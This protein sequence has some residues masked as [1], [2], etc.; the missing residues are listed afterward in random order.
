[1]ASSRGGI[2]GALVTR[3]SS[4]RMGRRLGGAPGSAVRAQRR[5]APRYGDDPNAAAGG[6]RGVSSLAGAS[7]LPCRPV[8]ADIAKLLRGSEWTYLSIPPGKNPTTA[9][10]IRGGSM[11][12]VTRRHS[13]NIES[14]RFSTDCTRDVRRYRKARIWGIPTSACTIGFLRRFIRIPTVA[15]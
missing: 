7:G 8:S 5:A 1:M 4:T 15:W 2:S 6:S 10:G 3:S 9:T 12:P 13:R 14:R 11:P